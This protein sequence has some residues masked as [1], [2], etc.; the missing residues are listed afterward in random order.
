MT[1]RT[2]QIFYVFTCAVLLV[3][4]FVEY[5]EAAQAAEETPGEINLVV[6]GVPAIFS[7]NNNGYYLTAKKERENTDIMVSAFD[8]TPS[9]K[10]ESTKNR[11]KV[12]G[13]I[14]TGFEVQVAGNDGE[15]IDLKKDGEQQESNIDSYIN[16]QSY[17]NCSKPCQVDKVIIKVVKVTPKV[18]AKPDAQVEP[19]TTDV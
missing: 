1:R 11:V 17:F 4:A 3:P 10:P 7:I 6:D 12:Y 16:V 2:S 14:P 9:E 19:K 18:E 8:E 13:R 15:P 5:A